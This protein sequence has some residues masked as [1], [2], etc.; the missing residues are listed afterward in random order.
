M[1]GLSA[2]GLSAIQSVPDLYEK[3][4]EGL[5]IHT[6][7]AKIGMSKN[8]K[9]DLLLDVKDILPE[10]VSACTVDRNYICAALSRYLRGHFLPNEPGSNFVTR[11]H[12]RAL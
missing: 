1:I 12:T 5:G 11:Y 2:H 9:I 10:D 6:T 4:V 7:R 8:I 3:Y